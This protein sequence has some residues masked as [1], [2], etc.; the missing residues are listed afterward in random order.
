MQRSPDDEIPDLLPVGS[1]AFPPPPEKVREENTAVPV[2]PQSTQAPPAPPRSSY[3]QELE[4]LGGVFEDEAE[5]DEVPLAL[6]SAPY[7]EILASRSLPPPAATPSFPA[8]GAPWSSAP[9]PAHNSLSTAPP[10]R[11]PTE[12]PAP[13]ELDLTALS[14]NTLE[15]E[16]LPLELTQVPAA[17]PSTES[18]NL[19][20]PARGSAPPGPPSS[21]APAEDAPWPA[22]RLLDEHDIQLTPE[23]IQAHAGSGP[24]PTGW[25]AAPL[26]FFRVLAAK[27][28][29]TEQE[30]L[31]R[32]QWERAKLRWEEALASYAAE[33][34]AQGGLSERTQAWFE[35]LEKWDSLIAARRAQ[36]SRV[37]EEQAQQLDQLEAQLRGIAQRGE[38][39]LSGVKRLQ[40]LQREQERERERLTLQEQRLLSQKHNLERRARESLPDGGLMPDEMAQSYLHLGE[41]LRRT[42]ESLEQWKKNRATSQ[43]E[44]R[45]AER[46]W[47]QIQSEYQL[48]EGELEQRRGASGGQLSPEAALLLEAEQGRKQV[49]VQAA[50]ALLALRGELPVSPTWR[51]E[52]QRL[53]RE[54]N[55][56]K[57]QWV[58]CQRALSSVDESWF[59]RGRNM[60]GVSVALFLLLL[61]VG[62]WRSFS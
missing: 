34:Q 42:Q 41:E 1:S 35:P 51:R 62:A 36:L 12:P 47:A 23:L 24:L 25:G 58:L 43:Q 45:E 2:A 22:G 3:P 37:E 49:L 54:A 17:S 29:L 14:Q 16:W 11:A 5:G 38:Q 40:I 48:L 18:S 13:A 55:Q 39:A 56:K 6:Q 59:A 30:R 26:Y 32:A 10:A 53:E 52:V 20:P 8:R 28:Q 46:G 15:E 4:L 60:V 7:H 61:L 19:L 21:S 33:F 9:P 50:S 31:A 57:E 44:L 27:K